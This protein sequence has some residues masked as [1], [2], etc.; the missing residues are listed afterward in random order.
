MY[1]KYPL[2]GDGSKH[3]FDSSDGTFADEGLPPTLLELG[4]PLLR[5]SVFMA[6]KWNESN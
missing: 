5:S 4:R 6:G 3:N 1:I 2:I